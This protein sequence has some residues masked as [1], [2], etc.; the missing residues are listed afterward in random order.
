M[1]K[2]QFQTATALLSTVKQTLDDVLQVP[3]ASSI[4]AEVE[5]K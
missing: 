2:A 5:K 4:I 1:V 3:E